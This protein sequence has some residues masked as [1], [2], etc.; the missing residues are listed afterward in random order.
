MWGSSAR[1]LWQQ[2]AVTRFHPPLLLII[3]EIACLAAWFPKQRRKVFCMLRQ[4]QKVSL[5]L[6]VL[7]VW[8][9]TISCLG[10]L[11]SSNSTHHTFVISCS[12]ISTIVL[13]EFS[14][15][16]VRLFFTNDMLTTHCIKSSCS[17]ENVESNLFLNVNGRYL[18]PASNIN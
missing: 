14:W 18:Q 4:H 7:H 9:N 12:H 15:P 2:A 10:N 3:K 13:F 8:G 16:I 1:F 17:S 11:A 5:H 6:I